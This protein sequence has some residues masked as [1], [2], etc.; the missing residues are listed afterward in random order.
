MVAQ[1]QNKEQAV[2]QLTYEAYR[3]LARVASWMISF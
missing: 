3:L 1:S 2:S